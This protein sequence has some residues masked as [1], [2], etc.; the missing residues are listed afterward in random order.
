M[1]EQEEL[2]EVKEL[3]D[4]IDAKAATNKVTLEELRVVRM[5]HTE[6]K[7]CNGECLE[8][9]IVCKPGTSDSSVG[10]NAEQMLAPVCP[11]KMTR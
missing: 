2:K 4:M 9:Y 11:N 7:P 8:E 10:G 1:G 6:C 5:A 3:E